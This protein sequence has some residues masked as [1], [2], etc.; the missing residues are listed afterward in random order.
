MYT[1]SNTAAGLRS[2]YFTIPIH[3][4]SSKNFLIKN[5]IKNNINHFIKQKKQ[6]ATM[7]QGRQSDVFWRSKACKILFHLL[8]M[9]CSPADLAAPKAMLREQQGHIAW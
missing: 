5:P 2:L 9:M 7:Q 4:L 8:K 3:L 1:A 6:P